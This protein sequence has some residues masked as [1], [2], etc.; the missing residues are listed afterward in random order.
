MWSQLQDT[1][2]RISVR[3]RIE[4]GRLPVVPPKQ[5]CAGYGSGH[6]CAVCDQPITSAQA[7]YVA[8][9]YASGRQLQFHA[10]CLAV[11]QVE[12]ARRA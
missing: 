7:E 8:Q 3:Q 9:D 2:L 12:C 5:I 10:A 6:L 1:A 4:H 11:W